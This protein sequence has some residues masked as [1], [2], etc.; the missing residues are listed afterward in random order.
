V[1][2]IHWVYLSPKTTMSEEMALIIKIKRGG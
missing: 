2:G 1:E